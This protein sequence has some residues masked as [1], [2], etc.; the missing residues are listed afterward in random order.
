MLPIKN[1]KDQL[2]E[3]IIQADQIKFGEEELGSIV[4]YV[5]VSSTKQR[6]SLETQLSDLLDEL[7]STIPNRDRT[8]RVLNNIHIMIE[9]FKQL[10]SS[11]STFD[12]YENV[13]GPLVKEASYK[14][15]INYFNNFNKNLYWIL[16]VVKNIKKIYDAEHID[17]DNNDIE[18]ISL[19][20]QIEKMQELIE[21]YKSNNLPAEQNKYSGLYFE[22]APYFT[23]FS[24]ISEESMSDIIIEKEVNTNLNTIVDNLTEMYSSIFSSNAVRSRR[25]VISKYNLSNSKL[26]T[27]ESTGSVMVTLRTNITSN[28]IMDIKSFVTLPEPIIRFSRINLPGT[29]ILDKTNLN[30]VFFK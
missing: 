1:V 14:P 22:L 12:K 2:R 11:F 23:P 25:F 10:R 7:L 16:P 26:D 27:I 17:E 6:Y 4:Q 3:F 28:D 20:S 9:R 15:L 24:S 30:L 5:D 18:N 19:Y 21:N 8:N 29:N 13:I